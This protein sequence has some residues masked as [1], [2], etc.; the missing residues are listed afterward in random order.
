[1]GAEWRGAA[2]AGNWLVE[3]TPAEAH[4]LGERLLELVREARLREATN[5]VDRALVS[6]SILPWLE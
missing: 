3:L 1:M 2:V 5:G 6:V 4:E